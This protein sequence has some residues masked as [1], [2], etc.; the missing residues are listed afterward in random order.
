[1]CGD[2]NSVIGMDKAEPLRRFVIGMSKGRF[3]PAL[4]EATLCGLFVETDDRTG[5]AIAALPVRDGGR[6]SPATPPPG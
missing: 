2:F 5:K 6:L 4:G 3:E 1:M